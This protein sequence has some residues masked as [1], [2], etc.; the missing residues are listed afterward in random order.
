MDELQLIRQFRADLPLAAGARERAQEV[1]RARIT[2]R[3]RRRKL[4]LA[5]AFAV[6]GL[7]AT[8]VALG[9]ADDVIDLVRGKPAPKGVKEL[10]FRSL[11]KF[12]PGAN[13]PQADA[14]RAR[15]VS[16]VRVEGGLFTLWEA[17]VPGGGWCFATWV[18]DEESRQ[19]LAPGGSGACDRKAPPHGRLLAF[20][21][22]GFTGFFNDPE[23]RHWVGAVFGI[24]PKEVVTVRVRFPTGKTIQVKTLPSFVSKARYFLVAVPRGAHDLEVDGLDAKGR[25]VAN[26]PEGTR[27]SFAS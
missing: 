7:L 6:A 22:L 2:G 3:R 5:V 9:L 12:P 4:V 21:G 14:S 8:G 1:L 23:G 17:P 16:A 18:L 19:L 27:L 25:V 10:S 11:D 24:A 13:W 15:G 26:T 20:P